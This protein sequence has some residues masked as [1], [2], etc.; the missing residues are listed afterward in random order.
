METMQ[1]LPY[2]TK[3]FDFFRG[4]FK[5]PFFEHLLVKT[6]AGRKVN[7]FTYRL[8]PRVYNYPHPSWRTKHKDGLTFKLD[9]SNYVDHAYYFE[10][11]DPG[12]ERL[13]KMVKESWNIMDVGSNIGTTALTF[14]QLASKGK[15]M[16]FEPNSRTFKRLSENAS[17]NKKMNISLNNVGLGEKDEQVKLYII[18]ETNPGMNRILNGTSVENVLGS[19]SITI[20]K[21]DDFIEK[22]KISRV[23]LIKIDVEG[24]EFNVLKGAEK[25]LNEFKP[26]LFIEV[27]DANISQ[28]GSSAKELISH[29]QKKGYTIFIADSM[30]KIDLTLPLQNMHIDI[31]CLPLETTNF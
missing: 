10:I 5:I 29:L 25:I 27:N 14:A 19:E 2:K 22:E 31:L 7:S 30:Q 4:I 28:N 16:A 23:D 6:K 8:I 1:K 11:G 15:V 9:I 24:Y 26:V 21:L 12:F 3:I 17:L 13:K 20:K 18:D